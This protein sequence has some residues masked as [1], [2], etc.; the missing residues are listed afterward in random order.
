MKKQ[1]ISTIIEISNE[2][3]SI[4]DDILFNE[5][6]NDNFDNI[7]GIE[8]IIKSSIE[9]L[10]VNRFLQLFKLLSPILDRSILKNLISVLNKI[11]NKNN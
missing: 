9:N 10:G 4:F 8:E 7:I 6:R 11:N 5:L 3:P 2:F 1:A